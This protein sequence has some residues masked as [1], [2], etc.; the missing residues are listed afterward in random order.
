[1]V[2]D[3]ESASLVLVGH[4]GDAA[5]GRLLGFRNP[6][7]AGGFDPPVVLGDVG[8]SEAVLEVVAVLEAHVVTDAR[9][10]TIG[11]RVAVR[12]LLAAAIRVGGKHLGVSERVSRRVGRLNAFFHPGNGGSELTLGSK[13]FR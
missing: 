2:D 4:A 5:I 6:E 11:D 12:E 1:M 13:P 3:D 7:V 8:V 9:V 10:V